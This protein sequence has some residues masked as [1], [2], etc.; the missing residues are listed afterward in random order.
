MFS[1]LKVDISFLQEDI[2]SWEAFRKLKKKV[3]SLKAVNDTSERAVKLMQAFHGN[4][5]TDEE[6]KQFLLRWVQEHIKMYPGCK[7]ETLKKVS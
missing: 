6:Q 2:S 1:R 3:F 4:I 5:I 7:K